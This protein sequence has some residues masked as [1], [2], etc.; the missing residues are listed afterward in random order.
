[1]LLSPL[2]WL[3]AVLAGQPQRAWRF[4]GVIAR[5]FFR[6]A[7]IPVEARGFERL[8]RDTAYVLVA[9]HGSYLDGILLV[10]V[11][12][13]QHAFI[14]KREFLGY[15]IPRLFLSAIGSQYVERFDSA[16]GVEDVRRF[17]ELARRGEKI[18]V[19]P[20][21]TFTRQTGLRPFLMGAFVIAA[22]AGIP[23][24]P[25]AILGAR[26]IL[27]D[28]TWFPSRGAVTI[29]AGEPIV[30]AGA[31]WAAAVALRE[32]AHAQILENCGEPRLDAAIAITKQR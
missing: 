16:R 7:G 2:A 32:Q 23:V 13:E 12:S 26:P 30:P 25:V 24:V 31:G 18:A 14:A 19:F 3:A 8:P 5:V 9:N 17:T 21:G 27:R 15:A 22:E 20:E 28:R 1:V 29:I 10:G 4:C 6:L 11:L